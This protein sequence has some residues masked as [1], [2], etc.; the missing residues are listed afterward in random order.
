M[1][2]KAYDNYILVCDGCGES[3]TFDS[4][5]DALDYAKENNW[6]IKKHETDWINYCKDCK[7]K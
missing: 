7:R 5:Q 4:F 6:V 3:E 1:I 2:D